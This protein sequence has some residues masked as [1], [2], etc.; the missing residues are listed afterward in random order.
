MQTVS[1]E[2]QAPDAAWE[3]A[4]TDVYQSD[5]QIL[6]VA[7]LQR[8]AEMAAQM[9]TTVKDSVEIPKTDL[10]IKYYIIGKTW[11]WGEALPAYVFINSTSDLD[12]LTAGKKR[13]FKRKT[14]D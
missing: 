4:I 13:L 1:V 12:K 2:L 7:Q 10:P 14:E 8:T 6:V 3:I 11:S 9:I 5:Q